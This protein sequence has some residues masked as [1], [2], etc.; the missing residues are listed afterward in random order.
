M[1]LLLLLL[2]HLTLL[3]RL[4]PLLSLLLQVPAPPTLELKYFLFLL[5]LQLTPQE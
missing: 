2:P 5:L 1:R 4:L 3:M